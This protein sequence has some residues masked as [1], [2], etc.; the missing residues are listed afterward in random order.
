MDV[1]KGKY[2]EYAD[3]IDNCDEDENINQNELGNE[4]IDKA[5]LEYLL[6][7]EAI[8]RLRNRHGIR[9]PDNKEEYRKMIEIEV[10]KMKLIAAEKE[11][12][13]IRGK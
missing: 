5:Y 8:E 12:A 10:L 1:Y 2:G 11:L 13:E 3:S 6:R 9:L 7:R 4:E